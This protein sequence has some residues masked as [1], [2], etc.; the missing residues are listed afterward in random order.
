MH[1]KLNNTALKNE[2]FSTI[3]RVISTNT[4]MVKIIPISFTKKIDTAKLAIKKICLK[5]APLGTSSPF[6]LFCLS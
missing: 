3:I 6:S 1:A 4:P 5:A 2:I